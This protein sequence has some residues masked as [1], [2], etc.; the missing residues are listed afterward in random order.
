M[1]MTDILLVVLLVAALVVL[2][3]LAIE[4]GAD[5]RT[6]RDPSRLPLPSY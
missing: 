3:I 5:S 4:F 6:L 1:M 2:D